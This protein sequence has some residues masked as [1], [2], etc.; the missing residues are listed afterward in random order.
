[1]YLQGF[2]Q[3]IMLFLDFVAEV[4]ADPPQLHTF[5]ANGVHGVVATLD[6][7]VAVQ[8]LQLCLLQRG[9]WTTTADQDDIS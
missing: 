6:E 2:G 3:D 4:I 5:G 9:L 8:R 7:L 1:M